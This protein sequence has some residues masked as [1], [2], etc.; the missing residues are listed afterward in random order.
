MGAGCVGWGGA[1]AGTEETTVQGP[2]RR[3]GQWSRPGRW[4]RTEWKGGSG[5]GK[6]EANWRETQEEEGT[7]IL[8]ATGTQEQPRSY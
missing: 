6:A 2:V 1:Q 8:P 7:G 3:L 5:D 4:S